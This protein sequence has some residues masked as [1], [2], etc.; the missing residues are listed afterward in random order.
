MADSYEKWM[1][2]VRAAF[3]SLSMPMADWQA[4]GVF[5]YRSEYDAGVA[6]AE[7]ALKANRHWWHEWN[8]SLNQECR[9]RRGCW[10]PRGHEGD[11]QPL[12]EP[13]AG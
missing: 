1:S 3:D 13:V 8:K 11:C 2:E 5:D 6:P 4:I 12:A 10:L 9:Q 7:A